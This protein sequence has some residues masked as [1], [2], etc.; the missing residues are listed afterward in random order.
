[1]G[2]D[3][4]DSSGGGGADD[5]ATGDG[6][7]GGGADGGTDESGSACT[8]P[9]VVITRFGNEIISSFGCTS[10]FPQG[11][12]VPAVTPVEAARSAVARLELHAIQI[13][14]APEVDP[15]LGHRHS[16]VNVPIWM[17]VHEPDERSW[18][19]TSTSVSLQGYTIT[20]TAHVDRVEWNMGD[21][22]VVSCRQG[23]AFHTSMGFVPSPDCGHLYKRTSKR[24]PD[25][26]YTVT[27]TSHWSVEWSANTGQSGVL[28]TTT[29]TSTRLEIG[30]LR[31]VNVSN[32]PNVT[33]T[34]AD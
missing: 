13:G 1:M 15:E 20:M 12:G 30:E 28:S 29:T 27:A 4:G 3:S 34:P 26:L 10:A 17:W 19:P 14:M 33:P 6:D 9:G 18:G 23:T 24:Q 8:D 32:P 16:Y 25:G 22:A 7:S 11:Q 5:G 21:G 2:W 31:A